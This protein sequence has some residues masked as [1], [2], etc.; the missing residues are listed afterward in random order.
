[1][2]NRLEELRRQRGIRQEDVYKRQFQTRKVRAM[3]E[4]GLYVPQWEHDAC[5]IGAVVR[6][7][8]HPTHQAVNDALKIVEKLEHRAGKDAAGETGDGVGILLQISH[9]FFK[10][11]A[12]ALSIHLGGPRDYGV[13][14]FFMPQ[15]RLRRNQ[16]KKMLEIISLVSYTHLRLWPVPAH[17]STELPELHLSEQVHSRAAL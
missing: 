5:G 2:K 13:G 11:A 12:A 16:A 15:D 3:E 6:I 10:K 17:W 1:M 9:K 7:D 4:K 14:M 8:G